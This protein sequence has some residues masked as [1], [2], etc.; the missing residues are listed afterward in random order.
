M[1]RYNRRRAEERDA[2][3]IAELKQ[4]LGSAHA[5]RPSLGERGTITE[6]EDGEEVEVVAS[7][8]GGGKMPSD[9]IVEELPVLSRTKS[10]KPNN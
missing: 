3:R 1:E 6:E 2:K 8:S 10:S 9:P 5:T 4:G 7:G